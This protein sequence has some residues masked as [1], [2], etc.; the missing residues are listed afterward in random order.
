MA[1]TLN[2][3]R[4]DVALESPLP[5]PGGSAGDSSR[6]PSERVA[7]EFPLGTTWGTAPERIALRSAADAVRSAQG[8]LVRWE[9]SFDNDGDAN[10]NRYIV[11]IQAAEKHLRAAR[12]AL[13]K[14]SRS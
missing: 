7:E 10:P 11:E 14:L 2:E 4:A 6:S 3:R 5:P 9:S 13:K 12:A 8:E 1:K